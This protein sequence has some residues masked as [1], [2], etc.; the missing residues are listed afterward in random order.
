V[1]DRALKVVKLRRGSRS[2]ENERNVVNKIVEYIN[3]IITK[4]KEGK[5]INFKS[6]ESKKMKMIS[7][8]G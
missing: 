7:M 1:R 6:E 3:F 2:V 8:L 5:K 4:D